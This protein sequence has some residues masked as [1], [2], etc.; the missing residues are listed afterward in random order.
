MDSSSENK[1]KEKQNKNQ[2]ENFDNSNTKNKTDTLDEF[3]KQSDQEFETLYS[4]MN[5]LRN[6]K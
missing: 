5:K 3:L 6:K 4:R 2:N 1:I